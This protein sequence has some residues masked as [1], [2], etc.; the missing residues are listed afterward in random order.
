MAKLFGVAGLLAL[1]PLVL[2]ACTQAQM[3]FAVN[4]LRWY[5][6]W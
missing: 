3:E 2:S 1:F 4:L 5:Y 6:G